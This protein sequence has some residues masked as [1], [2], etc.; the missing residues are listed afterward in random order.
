MKNTCIISIFIFF[1][2]G[3]V[4][5]QEKKDYVVVG[6]K[7]LINNDSLSIDIDEIR[8]FNKIKL[9]NNKERRY[10]YWFRKKVFK[11]YP[12]A[13]LTATTIQEIEKNLAKIKTKRRKKKYIKKAQKYLDE[14]FS[15]QLK[16]LTKT[17]GKVL[18]KLIYRQ[19][20]N[21]VFDLIKEYK[22]GWSAFW[23]HSAAK[24]FRLSLKKEYHPATDDFD[25]LIE[26]ILQ[27]AFVNEQ[28]EEQK[29]F[30]KIDFYKLSAKKRQMDIIEV[31]DNR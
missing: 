19:N 11:A 27:N 5:A 22:S 7:L 4:S 14:E 10:Y 24:L 2:F 28:L 17:E 29:P 23:Y 20:G 21:T 9:T 15:G 16:K 30:N 1:L 26:E 25:F 13:T 31:I 8:L 12:Y 3:F 6:D 18:I